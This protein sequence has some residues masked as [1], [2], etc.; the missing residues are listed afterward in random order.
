V[1]RQGR[2]AGWP[3]PDGLSFFSF[4]ERPRA[5][6]HTAEIIAPFFLS[7]SG[8]VSRGALAAARNR[9]RSGQKPNHAG[10]AGLCGSKQHPGFRDL[11]AYAELATA[12]DIRHFTAAPSGTIYGYPATPEQ[13]SKTLA[14]AQ[15]SHPQFIPHRHGC[16]DPR[17]M[18]AL[19]GGVANGERAPGCCRIHG[20]HARR[21]SS[22]AGARS[23]FNLNA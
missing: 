21:Q 17:I 4:V 19:M 10:L 22:S 5:Q 15:D 16:S 23:G 7:H 1:R 20:D 3:P 9:L 8:S 11:V 2:P 13:V 12:T 14:R 18:G 6:N